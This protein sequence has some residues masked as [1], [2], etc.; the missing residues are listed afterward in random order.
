[1][2]DEHTGDIEAEC[3]CPAFGSYSEYCKHIAAVLLQI[4]AHAQHGGSLAPPQNA[5]PP[6]PPRPFRK[7]TF[8]LPAPSLH[9]SSGRRMSRHD[10]RRSFKSSSRSQ[11]NI[12]AESRQVITPEYGWR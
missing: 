8:E 12:H 2:I 10:R 3:E 5:M 1:M 11:S 6:P 4:E 9:C 7:G